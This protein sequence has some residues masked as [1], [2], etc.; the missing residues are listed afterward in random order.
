LGYALD[1]ASLASRVTTFENDND[2]KLLVLNPV[3][4]L[5][6]FAL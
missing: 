1:D 3:L 2:L 5:D 4:Q 6:Q